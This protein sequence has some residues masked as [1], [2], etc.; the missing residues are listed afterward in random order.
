MKKNNK[1]YQLLD[2]RALPLSVAVVVAVA[3]S[4]RNLK[5]SKWD[6]SNQ[7]YMYFPFHLYMRLFS[8]S[9]AYFLLPASFVFAWSK[10]Y[11]HKQIQAL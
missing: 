10:N 3:Y 8:Y 4:N 6:S 9:H 1:N 5:N 2:S 11:I 7:I